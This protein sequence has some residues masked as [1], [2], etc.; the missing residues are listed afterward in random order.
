MVYPVQSNTLSDAVLVQPTDEKS[1]MEIFQKRIGISNSER[2]QTIWHQA[3]DS[4]HITLDFSQP[5]E[6]SRIESA[7]RDTLIYH[8]KGA[9]H[10]QNIA[11]DAEHIVS[12]LLGSGKFRADWIDPTTAK[13]VL[14]KKDPELMKS[15]RD[16][17][18]EELREASEHI[19][20]I[21]SKEE[22]V[23]NGLIG[24]IIA[25]LPYAYPEEG[26]KFVIPVKV[27]GQW[28][29]VEYTVDRKIELTHKWFSSPIAAY[30]LTSNDGPPLLTFLGTTYP[31]G[32]GYI[33]TLL[34]DFTPGLSV[35]HAPYLQGKRKIAEW[36]EDKQGVRLF[37]ASLGGALTLHVARNHKEKIDCVEAY[38]PAGLY[39]WDWNGKDNLPKINIY[40]QQNDL[41]ST[42]GFFPEGKNVSIFRVLGLKPENFMKAHIR[43]YTGGEEVTL[44]KS[45]PQYENSRLVRKILTILHILFGIVLCFL[46]IMLLYFLYNIL[47]RPIV[48]LIQ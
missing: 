17:L 12:F 32:E 18:R 7:L 44:L 8:G 26:E 45:S 15:F 22:I 48:H 31:A 19:P 43:A 25:I 3:L 33:A 34:A 36:L 11:T 4:H 1:L 5:I 46:P 14:L 24:N 41:V 6:L 38:N 23:F 37:G 13:G 35:G 40:Y 2:F 29:R 39:P 30:G 16:A 9:Q 42:L 27:D 47:A 10:N 21:G 20:E 28:K